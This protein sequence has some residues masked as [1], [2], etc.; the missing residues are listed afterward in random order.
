MPEDKDNVVYHIVLR[1][2]FL[3]LIKQDQYIPS[4]FEK[5]GF[6]HCTMGSKLTLLV[7]EDYFMNEQ[8]PILL[9]QLDSHIISSKLKLEEPSAGAGTGKKHLIPGALF[10]HIYGPLNL[11][12]VTG[13]AQIQKQHNCFCW[14]ESFEPLDLFLKNIANRIHKTT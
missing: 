1:E 7:L 6:I 2:D 8:N 10:P 4:G 14:P 3:R 9:L 13:V 11:S 12:A 5:D